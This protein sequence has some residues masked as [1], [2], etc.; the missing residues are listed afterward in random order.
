MAS[1]SSE[2]NCPH[3][4]FLSFR[5][6][7]VR[8]RFRSHFL[9]ELNRKL[10]TPFKD[11]E[12]VKGRSIGHELINA[13][14][15]SRISVVAFSDNYASSSWCLD[16]LVEIIKCRE[17]LGQ[18]VIPI[19][20]D[21]DPSHVKKQTE[22][23]GVIFEKTCQGRKEEE[24]LR[25]RRALTQA[26]T[27]A[28]EDSRNW[29]DEAKMIEKIVNDV[30]N[31]LCSTACNDFDDFVGIEAHMKNMNSLLELESE[32]VVMVGIW[33]PS[34]VGKTS[35]G[36]ALFSQ[37]S[38]Q[39]QGSIFIDKTK[40]IYTRANSYD[41]N[42]KLDLQAQFLS[43]ILDQKDIKVHSLH[44][45]IDRLGQKKVLVVFDDMDDQVL[46]DA[47]LGKTRCVGPRSRIVVISKD[48]E[49]LRACGIESDR[50]YEVEY[51]SK[52]LASQMFCRCAF[53]QDSPP[54]GFTEL[55]SDAVELSRN[56]PL[57]LNVLGSSLAGL[58]KEELEER[59]PKLVNRMAGQVD[60]TLK[61]S[62]DRLKEED[63][64]IFR[65]IACL[66]NHKPCDYVKGL[67][68][69]SKL[70]V[71]VGLVTLAERCLIQISEDKIIRMHDFLQKMGREI[72]RQPCIQDPGEREFL[73]DS[74][75]IYDVLVDGTGTKSVLGIFLNLREI[76][77]ELSISEEAFSGMKNLR[78]LRIYGVSEEDKET[79][80]QL[81]GGK[82]R[83]RRQLGLRKWY[84]WGSMHLQEGKNHIWRQLRL[85]EWWGCSMTSMPLNFRAENLVELR[86]PDSQLHKLWEGVEVL[87][88]L[89]TMDL[90]RSKH[91]KV[92]P[93]L[94]KATNLEE[95]YLEDCC[96]LVTIP[97]SIRSLKKLRKLDMKRC[98]KLR[99][100]PANIDLESLHSLNFSG[101][102]QLRS[103]PH[104]SRNISHLFLDETKIEEV[105]ERIEDIS[106]L[107]YV[108]MKGCKNLKRISPNI[109]KLEVI[110]FSDS[111]SLDEQSHYTQECAHKINIPVS[112]GS[113][114]RSWKNDVFLSFYGKDVRKTL[115]S[116]LYKEFSIRKVT[117]CTD[118]M[119]VPGDEQHGIR[120]SR[121]AVVVLSNNYV[122]SSWCLDGLVEIIKCGKEIG[123]EVIPVYYGVEPAHIR[124]QILDLGKA[125][126]KGYTVD[127]HK[128]R[129]EALTVLNQLKGYYFPDCDSEAEIIQKM[130]DDISFALNITP[131]EYLDVVGATMPSSLNQE[132]GEALYDRLDWNEKVLF[133]HIA[134]F[135]NNK[136]Y[137]NVMRLLED[138]EL[139][140][141]SGLNILLHTSLIRIS[142]KRV[143]RMKPVLQKLG[144]NI[145]LR[146]FINQ[147]AKRQFLMDTSEGCDVLIDQT[148]NERMFV[149]SFKVSETSK[150]D[151]R[152]R[153]MKKLQFLRMFKKSLY[154]K[155]VRVHL[156][157]GLFFVGM[158]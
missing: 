119:L 113:S 129:V 114:S 3:D 16:E 98:T 135:L 5:G 137:E 102:S 59:M 74:K 25:W 13:I 82:N 144:R 15:G 93:D 126:K 125:S 158:T 86:M 80:L 69:D 22:G 8:V 48:R 66:F 97:S 11:D 145:V 112:S 89:K 150:R 75:E 4:V 58:R 128:Q 146:P 12:I 78:F 118:D 35:I 41:Y 56:L 127:N 73:L 24:K 44:T 68:E 10:I 87:K 152:F 123:Q 52:E 140:V 85:L 37:L 1:S 19:F 147:P 100:L 51:P 57:A 76:E 91:L 30:S 83:R 92:F 153:G 124:T 54:D 39:F 155:Q 27:I 115:I 106:R 103:F 45:M 36:R 18:I 88:S 34:G 17:E 154:G 23:F 151:E 26:A 116:H 133:R 149:I 157:K 108:S 84:W 50:I 38:C 136:T 2:I 40:E 134:C 28:G 99:D 62:Y 67:L 31:K 49:L 65:H 141:G 61:D 117:A 156:V 42:T 120:E 131:K 101:C 32:R 29:S 43:E 71:D 53:G 148:G 79:I 96:S 122:S 81:R 9:K 72:V 33:G 142:E 111:Y 130:A 138:S 109:S 14:R 47:V 104:I 121:I 7:D 70:D 95:L 90:R 94:S 105:P 107:S 21:V 139:D 132:T 64:A 20:Y 46:L 63:K 55:A 6:E 77:D 60:K 110:F 143:I